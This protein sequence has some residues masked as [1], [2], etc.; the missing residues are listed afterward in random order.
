M[1]AAHDSPM[2][3]HTERTEHTENAAG[4]RTGPRIGGPHTGTGLGPP[5]NDTTG[6]DGV[7]RPR[8]FRRSRNERMI[9]GV[10]GGAAELFGIDAAL[11]RILLVAA[12]LLGFGSGLLIYVAC[13]LVVPE[14]D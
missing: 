12:T 11:V 13:W 4:N 10:C 7:P 5:G 1:R 14:R 6:A 3:E 9:A 2:N 8:T